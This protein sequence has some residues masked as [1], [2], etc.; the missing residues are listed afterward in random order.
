MPTSTPT[1]QPLKHGAALAA[2]APAQRTA[3]DLGSAATRPSSAFATQAQ[4][5]HSTPARLSAICAKRCA[6]SIARTMDSL[7]P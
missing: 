3:L 7:L 1:R 4:G 5:A 6:D 2:D